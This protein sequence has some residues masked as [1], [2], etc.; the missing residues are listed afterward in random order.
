M[1]RRALV[2]VAVAIA[3]GVAAPVAPA[4]AGYF[5]APFSLTTHSASFG[6]APVFMP[7]GRVAFGQDYKQGDKNQV[8]VENWNGTGLKCLTCTGD[9]VQNDPTNVSG[10]PAVRPRA[11]GSCSTPGGGTT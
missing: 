11:T 5:D 8:Y 10:V 2:G 6:Q 4:S 9:P 1:V 3:T 7:G